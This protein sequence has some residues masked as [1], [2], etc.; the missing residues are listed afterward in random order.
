MK[1]VECGVRVFGILYYTNELNE[2]AITAYQNR[3]GPYCRECIEKD[4][5]NHNKENKDE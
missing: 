3:K 1:C 5:N 2:P 4:I